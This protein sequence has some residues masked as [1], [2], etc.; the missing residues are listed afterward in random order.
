MTNYNVLTDLEIVDVVYST[1]ET[2]N[3]S[4]ELLCESKTVA[5]VLGVRIWIPE[6][7]SKYAEID[8]P[9]YDGRDLA[10][11]LRTAKIDYLA[12]QN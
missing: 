10:K 12:A 4:Y 3:G 8:V 9:T 2:G 1:N 11:W 6:D 5:H 7:E